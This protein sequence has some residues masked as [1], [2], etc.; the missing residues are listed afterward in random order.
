MAK[1]DFG[2]AQMHHRPYKSRRDFAKSFIGLIMSAIDYAKKDFGL[3]KDVAIL[4]KKGFD[5]AKMRFSETQSNVS[6][7][8]TIFSQ[9]TSL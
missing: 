6:I 8:E 2:L 5:L 4:A 3:T 9:A 7:L 1:S